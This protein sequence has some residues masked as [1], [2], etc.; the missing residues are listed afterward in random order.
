MWYSLLADVIVAF[1]LA[2]VSYVIVGQVLILLG[3]A[4]GWGWVRNLWFRV[5]H[6]AAILVVAIEAIFDITCPLTEWEAQLTHGVGERSFIGRWL[7][8]ILF[9]NLPDNHPVFLWSYVGVAALILATFVFVPPCIEGYR[10]TSVT[11]IILGLVS[12]MFLLFIEPRWIGA[13]IAGAALI[14]GALTVR[15]AKQARQASIST[16]SRGTP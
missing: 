12:A 16:E 7:G 8:D 4:L 2:Y 6:L 13:A 1:H 9:I 5:T 10:R 3:W 11:A 14:S 15:S